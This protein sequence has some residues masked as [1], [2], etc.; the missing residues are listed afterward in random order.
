[1]GRATMTGPLRGGLHRVRLDGTV[2]PTVRACHTAVRA[3]RTA[4][5]SPP[6]PS[7]GVLAGEVTS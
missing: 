4:V 3:C 1:M 2:P 7:A 6:A 5:P